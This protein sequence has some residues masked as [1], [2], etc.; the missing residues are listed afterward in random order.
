MILW[1]QML[2]VRKIAV[3]AFLLNFHFIFPHRE[4]AL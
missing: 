1:Q 3:R 2:A 4:T